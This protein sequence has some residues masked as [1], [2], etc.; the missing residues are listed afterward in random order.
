MRTIA[1]SKIMTGYETC[2]CFTLIEIFWLNSKKCRKFANFALKELDK[3]LFAEAVA[4]KKLWHKK[5]CY[6]L[7]KLKK[8]LHIE[9]GETG[10]PSMF[11]EL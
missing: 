9:N 11:R 1:L 6:V 10:P 5:K 7:T 2:W 4:E 8:I 3:S